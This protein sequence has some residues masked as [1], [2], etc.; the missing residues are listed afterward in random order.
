MKFTNIILISIPLVDSIAF[1]HPIYKLSL[2]IRDAAVNLTSLSTRKIILPETFIE[3]FLSWKLPI[4]VSFVVFYISTVKASVFSYEKCLFA[5]SDS[6][7]KASLIKWPIV[8]ND[9][10]ETMRKPIFP[11]ALIVCA[12]VKKIIKLKFDASFLGT[13]RSAYFNY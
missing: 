1:L 4:T 10:S 2:I 5:F 7:I 9:P 11:F 3:K 6:M 12:K 8:I 13:V